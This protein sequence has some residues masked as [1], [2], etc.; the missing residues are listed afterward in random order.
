MRRE[1]ETCKVSTSI[2]P[3]IKTEMALPHPLVVSDET[4]I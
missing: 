3:R 2:P 4:S 1:L